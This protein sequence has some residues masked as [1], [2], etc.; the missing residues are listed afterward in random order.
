MKLLIRY[1]KA[2][3]LEMGEGQIGRMMEGRSK[4]MC[5]YDGE[6]SQILPFC[7]VCPK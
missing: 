2:F 4:R 7:C 6:A 5:A 3:P 1:L